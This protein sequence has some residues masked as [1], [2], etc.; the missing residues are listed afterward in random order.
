MRIILIILLIFGSIAGVYSS[1]R[2]GRS[3]TRDTVMIADAQQPVFALIY[4]ADALGYFEDEGL[5]VSYRKFDLGKD[6]LSDVLQGHADLATVFQTPTVRR[7]SEGSDVKILTTLHNSARN[8]GIVGLKSKGIASPADLAGK[9]IAVPKGTSTEYFIDIVLRTEGIKKS[10]V[11]IV[12][13]SA[14]DSLKALKDGT[15]D[16]AS[17]FNPFLFSAIQSM[18]DSITVIHSDVYQD[19]SVLAGSEFIRPENEVKLVKLLTALRRAEQYIKDNREAAI[20]I[21]DEWLPQ[22]DTQAV[23][24]TWEAVSFPMKLDNKLTT[25]MQLETQFYFETGMYTGP[26]PD[27]AAS[28]ASHYLRQVYPDRVTV[29]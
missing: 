20:K 22:F 4:I 17:L 16:A 26:T 3:T 25:N 29:N 28:V 13:L 7:I 19:I 18:D 23:R 24:A 15:V 27:V 6:A 1:A 2:T 11:E 12:D 14:P 9:K 21:T 8:T 10:D 5:E